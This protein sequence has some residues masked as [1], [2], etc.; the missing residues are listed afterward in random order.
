[1]KNIFDLKHIKSVSVSILFDADKNLAGK[2]ISNWSDNPAGSVCT[3]QIILFKDYDCLERK[4][5]KLN[6]KFLE[7][8]EMSNILIGKAGGY[9]YDKL[10]QSIESA[11]SNNCVKYPKLGFGGA[12][13]SVAREWFKENLNLDLV[14]VL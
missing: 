14:E 3:S 2:I 10:S 4:K 13:L 1:M 8:V 12:G 5:H 7:N 9:G 6:S 11:I